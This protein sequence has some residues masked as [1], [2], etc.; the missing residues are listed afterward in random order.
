MIGLVH[1]LDTAERE[2]KIEDGL[3]LENWRIYIDMPTTSEVTPKTGFGFFDSL[4]QK[5]A[6]T[7]LKQVLEEEFVPRLSLEADFDRAWIEPKSLIHYLHAR[8]IDDSD[9]D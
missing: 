3:N 4:P 8:M 7:R 9:D 1:S 6:R 5:G 2:P